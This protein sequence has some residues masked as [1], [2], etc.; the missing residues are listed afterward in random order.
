MSAETLAH[1]CWP[2]RFLAYCS[3]LRFP[4]SGE[5]FVLFCSVAANLLA[6][7][8]CYFTDQ[9]D[10]PS[11]VPNLAR[12]HLAR[13][14]KAQSRWQVGFV[15]AVKKLFGNFFAA[16]FDVAQG[17]VSDSRTATATAVSR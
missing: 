9:F 5:R 6:K 1:L 3:S 16:P 2:T 13:A 11:E 4:V 7:T 14:A 15:K 10:S 17:V 12:P 8:R